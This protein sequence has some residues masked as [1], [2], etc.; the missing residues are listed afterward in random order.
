MCL[1]EA[2]TRKKK[3]KCVCRKYGKDIEMCLKEV[4]KRNWNVSEALKRNRNVSKGELKRH[5]NMSEGSAIKKIQV[6]QTIKRI[7]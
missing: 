7:S 5:L 3:S 1:K 4:L 2:L 6:C